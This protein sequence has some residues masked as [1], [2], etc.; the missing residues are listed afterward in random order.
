MT[1][2]VALALG[3][4]VGGP[5]LEELAQMGWDDLTNIFDFDIFF[6]GISL[7]KMYARLRTEPD[8]VVNR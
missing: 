1:K 7:P 5:V 2:L 4:L 6:D 8:R 3:L